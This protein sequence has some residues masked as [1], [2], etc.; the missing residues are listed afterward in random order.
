[1]DAKQIRQ[2]DRYG[3]EIVFIEE[4]AVDFKDGSPGEKAKTALAAIVVEI[5]NLAGEQVS[6]AG[7]ARMSG[8]TGDDM[9]EQL[10]ALMQQVNRAANA[11][12]DEIPNIERMFRMPRN[13]RQE[14]IIAYARGYITDA[15][16]YLTQFA[17]YDVP[18][19]TFTQMQTLIDQFNAAEA[20]TDADRER[21]GGATG[22]LKDAFQRGERLQT[23]L[24]AI[25]KNK[26]VA[27]PQKRSA[28]E[29]ASHLE[30]APQ[31]KK[32]EDNPPN[33]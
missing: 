4:N 30:R 26:Y 25:V 12:D 20:N 2:L 8:A 11:M 31:V 27:N 28:W 22:A 15:A 14:N 17:E 9:L 3:R 5:N 24:S 6:G 13:R 23:K 19:A 7:G 32:V 10:Y 21:V 18:A 1:M 16:P 33:P 29:I